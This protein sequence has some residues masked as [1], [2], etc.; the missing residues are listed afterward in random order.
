MLSVWSHRRPSMGQDAPG[1][2]RGCWL[3]TLPYA[4]ILTFASILA[5]SSHPC[6][7]FPGSPSCPAALC[8][9]PD[10]QGA[11]RLSPGDF[12]AS[13]PA[14]SPS[15]HFLAFLTLL[16]VPSTELSLHSEPQT[17]TL[18]TAGQTA[19]LPRGAKQASS[20]HPHGFSLEFRSVLD[21]LPH[22]RDHTGLGRGR[23]GPWPLIN[24]G[25]VT[26]LHIFVPVSQLEK[27]KHR[28]AGC[29]PALT[30]TPA[31]PEP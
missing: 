10:T 25:E 15:W 4:S 27:L 18:P 2:T 14:D 16:A 30:P 23:E 9:L 6:L 20:H 11:A 1:V 13:F 17:D 31:A 12:T 5:C 8:W 21:T 29:H 24:A 19:R 28:G 3:P 22:S 7:H 26:W